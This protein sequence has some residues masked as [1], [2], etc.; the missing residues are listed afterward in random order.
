[1]QQ[2]GKKIMEGLKQPANTLDLAEIEKAEAAIEA[3]Q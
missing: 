1:M 2:E 3:S